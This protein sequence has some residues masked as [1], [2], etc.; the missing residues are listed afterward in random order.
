LSM[1]VD[2]CL[3]SVPQGVFLPSPLRGE[4][5]GV[6]GLALA[7]EK[8]P[9]PNPSP[10]GGEGLWEQTLT[11]SCRRGRGSTGPAERTGPSSA[12]ERNRRAKRRASRRDSCRPCRRTDR[13]SRRTDRRKRRRAS[14]P[15]RPST[16]PAERTSG[17]SPSRPTEWRTCRT[18]AAAS[19]SRP[20]AGPRA[21]DT[22]GP[23]RRTRTGTD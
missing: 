17:S 14:C 11:D 7:R 18:P 1:S 2:V 4:G 5:L 12:P 21:T 6:R 19:P 10:L 8:T 23:T 15:S 16:E 20:S 13:R 9:H 3:E 22:A